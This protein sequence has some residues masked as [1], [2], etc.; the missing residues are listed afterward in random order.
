MCAP[1]MRTQGSAVIAAYAT[2]LAKLNGKSNHAVS[3]HGKETY[4]G[5]SRY[6]L[7]R[8]IL[9]LPGND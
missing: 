1:F 6:A 3:F 9:P 5:V 8:V 7:I 4:K 2:G